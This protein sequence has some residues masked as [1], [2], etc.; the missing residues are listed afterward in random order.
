[1][2]YAVDIEGFERRDVIIRSPGILA[3]PLL[4]VDGQTIEP[5]PK[6]GE[7]F[8]RRSDGRTARLQFRNGNPLDPIPQLVV[9]GKVIHIVEPFH[10]YQWLW[11][12]MPLGLVL[13]GLPGILFGG[14]AVVANVRIFRSHLLPFNKYAVTAGVTVVAAVLTQALFTLICLL[15]PGLTACTVA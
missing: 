10:W 14:L 12:A 6:T 11:M 4:I 8:V 7:M 2:E 1:M 9:E 13:L 5:D 15:F 3:D